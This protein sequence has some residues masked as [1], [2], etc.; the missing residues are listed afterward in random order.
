MAHQCPSC[1]CS[2]P[3]AQQRCIN[4]CLPSQH[5]WPCCCLRCLV[6][7]GTGPASAT[8]V[9]GPCEGGMPLSFSPLPHASLPP[10]PARAHCCH[11]YTACA[12]LCSACAHR[13]TPPEV[14]SAKSSCRCGKARSQPQ[15]RSALSHCAAAAGPH[16]QPAAASGRVLAPPI[17][18]CASGSQRVLRD[19][20]H[21]GCMHSCCMCSM[22]QVLQVRPLPLPQVCTHGRASSEHAGRISMSATNQQAQCILITA[23]SAFA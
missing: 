21:D 4:P 20:H 17:D 3:L 8:G 19:M 1:A 9:D 18:T 6:R 15:G 10:P 7:L 2:N 12:L 22:Q 23:D 5:R 11:A 14:D 13:M 16:R